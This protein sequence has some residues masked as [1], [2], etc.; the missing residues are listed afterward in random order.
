MRNRYEWSEF[1]AVC[2]GTLEEPHFVV[3][4][5]FSRVGQGVRDGGLFLCSSCGRR[6]FFWRTLVLR[7]LAWRWA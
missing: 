6:K 1:V 7:G 4:M 2:Q 3:R 5:E